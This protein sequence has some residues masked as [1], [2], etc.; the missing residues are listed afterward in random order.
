MNREGIIAEKLANKAELI[1]FKKAAVKNCDPCSYKEEVVKTDTDKADKAEVDVKSDKLFKTIVGNTY[2]FMDSHD[3]VHVKGCFTK[4][5]QERKGLIFHL[6]DHLFRITA[7]VGQPKDIYEKEITWKELGADYKGKT[8]ALMMDS[9]IIKEW[10]PRIYKGYSDGEIDQHS[11]G[12]QYV[13][14]QFAADTEEDEEA[15]KLYD[16]YLPKIANRELAEKKGYFFIVKEARLREISSVILGSNTVTPTLE[17]KSIEPLGDTQLEEP[18][19]DTLKEED[20][21][22]LFNKQFKN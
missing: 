8:I 6:H 1:E 2:Y 17:T 4:T 7:K 12:M 16:E 11:V 21:I 5:I 14:I 20:F 10:N 15:K 18:L 3:D 19:K 13:K 22:Q 9:E